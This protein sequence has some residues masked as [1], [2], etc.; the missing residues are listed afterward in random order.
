MSVYAEYPNHVGTHR[1]ANPLSKLLSV[2]HIYEAAAGE[3]VDGVFSSELRI[4]DVTRDEV[5]DDCRHSIYK[6][7][8][9]STVLDFGGRRKRTLGI[10]KDGI[11][12]EVWPLKHTLQFRDI[13]LSIRGHCGPQ[14]VRHDFIY[15]TR[16][17]YIA[18]R[19]R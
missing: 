13:L 3:S 9:I 5:A 15:L 18:Y 6:G 10:E 4:V 12:P 1:P 7:R 8:V 17:T 2:T 14:L 11:L 19:H 16:H